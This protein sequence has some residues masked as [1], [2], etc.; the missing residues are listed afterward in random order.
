MPNYGQWTPAENAK[1]IGMLP[2]FRD[3]VNKGTPASTAANVVAG[4]LIKNDTIG[5]F[6]KRSSKVS[7]I[8]NTIEQHIVHMDKIASGKIQP[9]RGDEKN[10]ADCLPR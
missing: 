1:I 7:D 6:Q 2:E 8:T 3:L 5:V 9:E 10:W 4:V